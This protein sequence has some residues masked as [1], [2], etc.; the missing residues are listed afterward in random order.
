MFTYLDWFHN[1]SYNI[2]PLNAQKRLRVY[3]GQL[4]EAVLANKEK[5]ALEWYIETGLKLRKR[6]KDSI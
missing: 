3:Q 1:E 6:L 4:K 5:W 2:Q